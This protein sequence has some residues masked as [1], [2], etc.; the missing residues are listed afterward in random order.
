MCQWT[1]LVLHTSQRPWPHPTPLLPPHC[2]AVDMEA[3]MERLERDTHNPVVAQEESHYATP[4]RQLEEVMKNVNESAIKRAR[5]A[6][7]H[8]SLHQKDEV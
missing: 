1:T 5:L 6:H 2:E 3:D 8:D 7:H 4:K